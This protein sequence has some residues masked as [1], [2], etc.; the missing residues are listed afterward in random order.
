MKKLFL[1]PLCLLF[2]AACDNKSPN[3]P[4]NPDDP[5]VGVYDDYP[6]SSLTVEEQKDKLAAESDVIL[7]NLNNL[8]NANGIKVL[9]SFYELLDISAPELEDVLDY[10]KS[11]NIVDVKDMNGEFTW[12]AATKSWNKSALSN[13]VI[14]NFPVENST[15][16]N[17]KVEITGTGS[18]K[19]ERIDD[20][21]TI[22]LPK[23]AKFVAFLSNSEVANIEIKATDLN[24]DNIAKDA[25]IKIALGNYVISATAQQEADSKVSSTFSF[26]AGNN[27]ILDAVLSS[28]IDWEYIYEYESYQGGYWDN[29]KQEWVDE[30][31]TVKDT[32]IMLDYQSAEV[33]IG[34]NLAIVGYIDSKKFSAEM[35]NIDEDFQEK[36]NEINSKYIEHNNTLYSQT[37]TAIDALREKYHPDYWNNPQYDL[38]YEALIN[39]H[40]KRV[41]EIRKQELAEEA[42][43]RKETSIKEAA[44]YNKHT[45]VSLISKTDKYKIASVKWS[46]VEEKHD[47]YVWG[48]YYGN[49]YP[50]ESTSYYT[51]LIL[52]FNDETEASAE[53]FFG[54]GFD[55]VINAWE[56][57]FMSFE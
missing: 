34:S 18:G 54:S 49:Q 36:W 48:Y 14:F 5:N 55:R 33:N 39:N 25:S 16:N 56:D 10:D 57:F 41:V 47:E 37:Y 53:T 13:K 22:E 27:I 38:E 31:R 43:L 35:D 6:Y 4:N 46:Y 32:T 1:I 19:W 2:I 3:D 20:D 52:V 9:K 21:E 40:D 44:V 7:A 15:T 50:V 12:N 8:P 11:T 28:T 24:V 29:E 30:Y 51:G 23:D 26:K 42:V 45:E 17:G